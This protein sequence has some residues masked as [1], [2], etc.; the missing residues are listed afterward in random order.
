MERKGKMKTSYIIGITALLLSTLC[1]VPV[2][3]AAL[4][5]IDFDEDYLGQQLDDQYNSSFG[6]SFNGNG[7]FTADAG[8]GN[9]IDSI[10]PMNPD[11]WA[12]FDIERTVHSVSVD[13]STGLFL[14]MEIFNI[15]NIRIGETMGFAPNGTL[16]LSSDTD[17]IYS[18]RIFDHSSPYA[19]DNFNFENNPATPVPE[20]G[21]LILLGSGLFGLAF[22]GRKKRG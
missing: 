3:D 6:V 7:V 13:Y 11:L 15:D 8:G 22:F 12:F 17:Y 4:Y 5:S 9:Q 21:T 1:L 2:A 10:G 18:V 20:P 19:I 16:S 14:Q